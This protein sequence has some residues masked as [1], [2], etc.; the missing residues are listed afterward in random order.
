MIKPAENIKN[1]ERS[2]IRRIMEA[3]PRG[4]INLGLGEIQFPPPLY[5]RE[6]AKQIIGNNLLGYTPNAGLLKLRES[7]CDY[8]QM[9]FKDNVC[10]TC[11]AEE[12]V[13][14]VM[15]SYLNAGDEVIIAD[16]TYLAYRTIAGILG[17]KAVTFDQPAS[18]NFSLDMTSFQ[19]AFN[20][21]TKLVMLNNP[22]NP[23]GTCFTPAEIEM[24]VQTCSERKVLLVVDEVYRELFLEERPQTF[25][26][27][28]VDLICI[29]S[30]SKSHCL[31][32]WRLGWAVSRQPALLE[33]VINVHQYIA[34]CAPTLSQ[35]IAVEAFSR[36]GMTA[37]EE[38]RQRLLSNRKIVL[39]YLTD[40]NILPNNSLPYLFVRVQRDDNKTACDLAEA[41]VIVIPG[42]AFGVNAAGWIRI[43]CGIERDDLERGIE[44][45]GNYLRE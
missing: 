10:I 29:S 32:G 8:Y 24:I 18:E 14:A 28:D 19:R 44:I 1:L 22:A 42:S 40:I 2:A 34:T 45:I 9:D 35:K 31:S 11:G 36:T 39:Q 43:N 41:G 23:M 20:S 5:L 27:H 21:N 13:F 12:A 26:H 6:Q 30:L 7:I 25:L 37:S 17:A 3:A 15:F 33:P 16:P 4:A 38:I